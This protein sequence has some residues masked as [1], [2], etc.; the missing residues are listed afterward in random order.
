MISS[1][2]AMVA[3]LSPRSAIA[4]RLSFG[5]DFLEP[6][7]AIVDT[8]RRQLQVGSRTADLCECTNSHYSLDLKPSGFRAIENASRGMEELPRRLLPRPTNRVPG[9][10]QT[11]IA[12]VLTMAAACAMGVLGSATSTRPARRPRGHVAALDLCSLHSR[13]ARPLLAR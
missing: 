1:G 11:L 7:G 8:V 3:P 4:S 2:S 6:A 13:S 5:R 9:R 12:T 10:R